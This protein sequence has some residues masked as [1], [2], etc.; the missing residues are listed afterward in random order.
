MDKI[1]ID[2]T[3]LTMLTGVVNFAVKIVGQVDADTVTVTTQA[4]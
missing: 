2:S 3:N 1:R 4:T